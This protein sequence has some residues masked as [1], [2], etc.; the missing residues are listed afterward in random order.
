MRGWRN[1]EWKERCKVH[2]PAVCI[3][4]IFRKGQTLPFHTPWTFVHFA[5]SDGPPGREAD[6]DNKGSFVTQI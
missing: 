1:R 5:V 3:V 2:T 4:V 6:G